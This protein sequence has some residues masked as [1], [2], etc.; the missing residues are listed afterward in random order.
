VNL[1]LGAGDEAPRQ[2]PTVR[3]T[4]FGHITLVEPGTIEYSLTSGE[5]IAKFHSTDTQRGSCE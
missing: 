1:D 3:E 5:V 4:L 2:W